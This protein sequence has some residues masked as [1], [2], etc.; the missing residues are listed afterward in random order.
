LFLLS[1]CD[2]RSEK[3]ILFV[4]ETERYEISSN[5][6]QF[7]NLSLFFYSKLYSR[8]LD[9]FKVCK[10]GTRNVKAMLKDKKVNIV[11]DMRLV[12]AW[13]VPGTFSDKT[14]A[15]HGIVIINSMLESRKLIPYWSCQMYFPNSSFYDW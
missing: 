14:D 10:F 11:M 8:I 12:V 6:I 15:G 1:N 2:T 5:F 3:K 4:N 7:S 9:S 13:N